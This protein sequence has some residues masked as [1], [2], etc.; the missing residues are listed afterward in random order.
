MR[1][2]WHCAFGLSL[3]TL[4]TP[5]SAEITVSGRL[6]PGQTPA[7][8]AHRSADL[9]G[10]PEQSLAAIAHALSIGVDI[11]H[12]NPQLTKDDTYILMHD[13][14]LNR[15]TNVVE[16]Y[17]NGPPNGPSRDQ[18][19]GRDYVR[20]YTFD[21]IR[22][23]SLLDEV[24]GSAH[25]VPSLQEALDLI[26]GQAIGL[27][28]LKNYEIESLKNT[29]AGDRSGSLL[30]FGVFYS[31]PTLL[32][33]V[34]KATGIGVVVSMGSSRNYI[35]DLEKLVSG[36]GALLVMIC[37]D[38]RQI[39][40]QFTKMLR[41]NDLALCIS[42]WNHQ[43]DSALIHKNDPGPWRDALQSGARA[44]STDQPKAVLDL[45]LK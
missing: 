2:V 3:L 22:R 30:L 37:A 10:Q 27:L 28:G 4:F 41:E 24:H 45:N 33:D 20:D 40:P 6:A 12:L 38:S 36:V 29:L 11:I 14:T 23:L 42:G 19:G 16:V 43:E 21:E 26:D 18:R 8:I 5:V 25:P 17:P 9:G 44:V 13:P 31:D 39:T 35:P 32:H 15:T 1:T 7:I 34:S